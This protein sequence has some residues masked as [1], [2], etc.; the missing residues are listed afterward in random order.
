VSALPIR[1][2]LMLPFAVAMAVVFA[3][4][5]AFVY[6]RI[7]STLLGTIDA[8]LRGQVTEAVGHLQH[9]RP[10]LDRD[11]LA[12][13]NLAQT[14]DARGRVGGSQ[15][16]GLPPLLDKSQL[17][18]VAQGKTLHLSTEIANLNGDWR[19]L[20]VRAGVQRSR[21]VLVVGRS[22]SGRNET[23]ARL[24]REL[25]F[26]APA[27]L[28]L[29]ALAG[30]LLAGAALRPV[31][32]MRRRAGAISAETPGRRLPVPPAGDEISRLAT[33]LNDMLDR[34]EAA[35]QHERR[36]VSD[37]SHE[38][39]TPLALLRTELEL[40]LRRPRTH[41]ELE[42]AVRSAAEETE[43]LT[44][45]AED[46]LLIARSDQGS[47]PIR[48]Q[49]IAAG[50]VLGTIAA[51]FEPRAR[52]QGREIHVEIADDPR[53]TADPARLEQ[54]IGNLVDNALVHGAGPITLTAQGSPA[55][56]ELHVL[57]EG[58]GIPDA[59][60]ERAFDRFSRADAARGRGGSGLGLAIVHAIAEAHD[61]SAGI[62][63]REGGGADSWIS[64][65]RSVDGGEPRRS[66]RARSAVS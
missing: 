1:L 25:S 47:L 46:L 43:R 33:T 55:G 37:A 6:A 19:L 12:S 44:R 28:L 62:S 35:L 64:V 5:G 9:G 32:A 42:E 24:R 36:F 56:V 65:P 11:A 16:P 66:P 49:P 10:L 39:R 59:F 52:E 3:A 61:G 17:A 7:A 38:L 51:R 48:A 21:L 27:A 53:V 8:G 13:A 57:D 20:A 29:A 34:L 23:L 4:M 45:L 2:R 18:A 60:A 40:A 41:A 26:A 31:E 58:P 14:L 15:P 22:L 50:D 54:A 63:N 30:Y